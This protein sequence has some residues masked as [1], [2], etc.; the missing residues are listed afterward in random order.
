[1]N[2]YEFIEEDIISKDA[3]VVLSIGIDFKD[4]SRPVLFD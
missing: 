1:M 4:L 2:I 3:L